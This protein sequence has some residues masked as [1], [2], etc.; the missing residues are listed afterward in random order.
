M[1]PEHSARSVVE[2][3]QIGQTPSG[4]D[5]VLH[6][7]PEAFHGMQMVTTVGREH[8]QPQLFVPVGQRRCALLRPV[9][10]TA[11]GDHDDL[12]PGMATEG[13]HVMH[14]LAQPLRI[15]MGDDL[16]AD[17]RGALVDGRDDAEQDPAGAAAPRAILPPRRALEACFACDLALAQGAYREASA[18]GCAPP[19]RP[20]QGKTPHESFLFVEPHDLPPTGPSL[21]GGQCERSPRQRS[22][23]RRKP[24]GGTAVA[25]IFFFHTSRI[26]S[27]RSWP[28]GWRARTGASS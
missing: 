5:P 25:D 20:G 3:M 13:H 8:M 28:P 4:A 24:P 21:S 19:A 1:R 10:A 27:R 12:L 9:D 2:L 22:R 7:T 15:T 11:V 18:L 16:R 6:H 17:L 14:L 23:G 26:L